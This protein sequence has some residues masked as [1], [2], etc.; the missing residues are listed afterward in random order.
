MQ[1]E[2]DGTQYA[3]NEEKFF[4]LYV[5]ELLDGGW[6]KSATYQPDSFVLTE[7]VLASMMIEKK[8]C[9]DIKDIKLMNGH[10]YTADWKLV[11]NKKAD[12][13]FYWLGMGVYKQGA[14]P[15]SKPRADY[16]VPFKAEVDEHGNAFSIIDVKG[17]ATGRNNSSAITFPLNQKMLYDKEGLFVQKVVVS[18]SDKGLFARTFTPI[19]VITQEVYKRDC[20]FGKKGETKLKYQPRLLQH[21]IKLKNGINS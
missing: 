4:H 21:W 17:E 9:S 19:D 14:Y 12:G 3:S 11:W 15:F 7:A 8:N 1:I 6:L 13:V 18:L 5:T 20:K 10:S 16:F 2:F